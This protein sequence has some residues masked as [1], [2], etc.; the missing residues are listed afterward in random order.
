LWGFSP[1]LIMSFY[2]NTLVSDS[3]CIVLKAALMVLLFR[4]IQ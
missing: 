2:G 3:L 1:H 4:H